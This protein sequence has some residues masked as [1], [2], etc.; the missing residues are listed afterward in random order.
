MDY[1]IAISGN[2]DKEGVVALAGVGKGAESMTETR[3]F[4]TMSKAYA[5]AMAWALALVEE[6][7]GD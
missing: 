4:D 5:W 7:R 2:T 1:I 6:N 3:E